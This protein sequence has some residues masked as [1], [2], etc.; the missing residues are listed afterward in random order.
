MFTCFYPLTTADDIAI[1]LGGTGRANA[2]GIMIQSSTAGKKLEYLHA[3]GVSTT[4]GGSGGTTSGIRLEVAGFDAVRIEATD[5]VSDNINAFG[6]YNLESQFGADEDVV[7]SSIAASN[8]IA[9]GY[10]AS[11]NVWNDATMT[12]RTVQVS[13]VTGG[14][15]AYGIRLNDNDL[16]ADDTHDQTDHSTSLYAADSISVSGIHVD[17]D[18]TKGA[19]AYGIYHN[20]SDLETGLLSISDVSG[21]TSAVGLWTVGQTGQ[22]VADTVMVRDVSSESGTVYGILADA[23]ARFDSGQITVENVSTKDSVFGYHIGQDT[24]A[25][26]VSVLKIHSTGAD[27]TGIRIQEAALEVAG[28]NG[29]TV[30]VTDVTADQGEAKGIFVDGRNSILGPT[31]Y[32]SVAGISGSDDAF[33]LHHANTSATFTNAGGIFVQDISSTNGTAYGL[34]LQNSETTAN[35]VSVMDVSAGTAYGIYASSVFNAGGMAFVGNITGKTTARGLYTT[36]DS[37]LEGLTVSN[38]SVSDAYGTATGISHRNGVSVSYLGNVYVSDVS[39]TR[40]AYG[41]QTS[42]VESASLGGS[43]TISGV[44]ADDAHGL[45]SQG[46]KLTATGTTTIVGIRGTDSAAALSVENGTADFADV[47]I[48]EVNAGEISSLVNAK[49]NADVSIASGVI[50]S[51]VLNDPLAYDGHFDSDVEADSEINNINRF[52]LRSVEGSAISLGGENGGQLTIVGAIVAGR[53]TQSADEA[54]GGRVQL[55]ASEGSAIYG[56]VYA[57]N[58][59]EVTMTLSGSV[60]EGQIDDYHELATSTAEA[61]SF[62]NA[63]FIDDAGNPIDVTQAGSVHLTLA[64]DSTW[65]ARGKS[66]VESLTFSGTSSLVDL[67]QNENSSVTIGTLTGSNGVFRMKLGK[68]E[69][70]EDGLIHS[71]MLYISNI[72]ADLQNRIEVVF[73]DGV[74]SFEELDGLRFATSSHV[75]STKHL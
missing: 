6:I 36:K 34:Y 52:A 10:F 62:R 47:V 61:D 31:S 65:T 46:G 24:G 39:G 28:E 75:D 50:R 15:Y 14:S 53:G 45:D 21:K 22:T 5:I 33:G 40:Y 11:N 13:D 54:Q 29:L 7:L 51:G 67:S 38:V 43:L 3:S 49:T 63:A 16:T 55:N 37:A 74:T 42:S 48:A 26:F 27:A 57:G 19:I 41:F 60:L 66:F 17:P 20:G 2:A 73:A 69:A 12:A 25:D 68:P 30:S 59:G 70:G 18:S 4:A 23:D 71:D 64:D 58:G 8:A 35:D 44:K 1:D 56:D 32:I 72:D 9:Y